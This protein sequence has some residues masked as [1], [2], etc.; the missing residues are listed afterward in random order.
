MTKQRLSGQLV[1]IKYFFHISGKKNVQDNKI[2]Y[3]WCHG[4]ISWCLI[5]T[6]HSHLAVCCTGTLFPVLHSEYHNLWMRYS[7]NYYILL[8][9]RMPTF[10]NEYSASRFTRP[11]WRDG[12]LWLAVSCQ[13]PPLPSG[14]IAESRI[15]SS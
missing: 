3:F 4:K 14:K 10:A 12:V 1:I 11:P 2:I 7:V 13:P 15:Y 5:I 9:I 8:R 6:D